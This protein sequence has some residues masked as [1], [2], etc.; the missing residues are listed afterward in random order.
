M[1]ISIIAMHFHLS[2]VVLCYSFYALHLKYVQ[3]VRYMRYD[4]Y[5]AP[6]IKIIAMGN[7]V[8]VPVSAWSCVLSILSSNL[9]LVLTNVISVELWKSAK[10]FAISIRIEI[11]FRN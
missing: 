4:W 10:L 5:G 6:N 2:C 11:K 1:H 7:C 9:W 3:Y 8:Y